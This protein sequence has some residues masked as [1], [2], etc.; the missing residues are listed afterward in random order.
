MAR[1]FSAGGVV[2]HFQKAG[3]QVAV[4]EPRRQPADDKNSPSRRKRVA[5]W[6][7]PKGLVDEG[8]KAEETSLREVR[9]ETG[10]EAQLV[11]KLA[12]IRYFYVRTWSDNQRVFKIVSFFL[13]LYRS[14]KIGEISQE[15][16]IEVERALWLPLEEA[17]QRLS[18]KG[19]REV[20]RQAQQ[21]LQAHPELAAQA[22]AQK[23]RE[24]A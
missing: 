10:I 14:G 11:T 19:E 23:T 16:R 9:E 4:I 1:E 18:Y 21:Y 22:G 13:L 20:L 3:W 17:A 24:S 8:E 2:L 5:V 7:L 15:M 6:A 12:D